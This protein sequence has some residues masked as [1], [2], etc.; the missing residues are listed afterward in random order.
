[1]AASKSE[2]D[3]FWEEFLGEEEET[4][5][6]PPPKMK[7]QETPG[8]CHLVFCNNTFPFLEKKKKR[9]AEFKKPKLEPT[10]KIEEPLEPIVPQVRSPQIIMQH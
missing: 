8:I 4:I 5:T 9:L 10:Q 2:S 1:M 7:R 3:K 6:D